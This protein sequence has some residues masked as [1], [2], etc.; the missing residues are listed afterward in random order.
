MYLRRWSERRNAQKLY[1]RILLD[2]LTPINHRYAVDLCSGDG[3][4]AE[5]LVNLGWNPRDIVCIDKF[6]SPTPLVTDARWLY[7]DLTQW[8]DAITGNEPVPPI[9]MSM[10][11]TFHIVISAMTMEVPLQK[12][13]TVSN[14]LL[15]PGG[16]SYHY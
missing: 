3:V 15:A 14:F 6:S 13:E 1:N 9:F 8:A 11:S 4:M 12:I 16:Y 7:V 2:N 5:I 10:K